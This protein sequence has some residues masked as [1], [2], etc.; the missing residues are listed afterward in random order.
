MLPSVGRA[1]PA[2]LKRTGLLQDPGSVVVVYALG[3]DDDH[4]GGQSTLKFFTQEI[5]VRTACGPSEVNEE[6]V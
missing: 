1:A 5:D 2:A 3:N 6:L 4:S